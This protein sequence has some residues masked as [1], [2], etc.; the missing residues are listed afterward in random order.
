M[1]SIDRG[2]YS[3]DG[4]DLAMDLHVQ[5]GSFCAVLGP[6]GS[7]KSTLLNVIAGFEPLTKGRILFAGLD[8]TAAPPAERPVTFVFQDHN[9]FAHLD[10]WNNV[11]LGISPSL[12]L[13]DAQRL[14]VDT[15]LK[16][17][18]ISQLANRKPGD[19][20]GGERQ[21]IAIARV[22]VRKRP[23]LLLDEAFAALGPGLRREML[24][25]VKELHHVRG[26]TTLMVTHQPEDAKGLAESIVFVDAG[27]VRPI[28]PVDRFFESGD[29]R[30]RAYLGD[31]QNS[32][33]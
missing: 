10:A 30:I 33:A 2:L 21:R 15:A 1:I 25:L 6:S 8:A 17:T 27:V 31:W 16:V 24:A 9:S 22:L 7:G 29:R 4:F 5:R 32:P 23:I 28:M 26:L 18:G 13:T 14:D 12:T 11:A 3:R 19:M 20:S